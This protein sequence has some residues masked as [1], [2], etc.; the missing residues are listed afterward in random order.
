[1]QATS[2]QSHTPARRQV[3]YAPAFER[4]CELDR[5]A[6]RLGH[7]GIGSLIDEAVTIALPKLTRRADARRRSE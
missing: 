2:S 5:L 1:M 7:P 3:K 6:T 4:W